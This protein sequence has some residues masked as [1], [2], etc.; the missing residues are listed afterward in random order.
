[1]SGQTEYFG[2][3]CKDSST[4]RSPGRRGMRRTLLA[5]ACAAGLAVCAPLGSEPLVF[6]STQLRPLQEATTMRQDILAGFGRPVSFEPLDDR[7]GFASRAREL[8]RQPGCRAVFGGLETDFVTLYRAGLLEDVRGILPTLGNRSFLQRFT[9]RG[10]FDSRGAYFVPWMQATYLMAANRRSLR[11]LPKGAD[12][13]H[14]TYRQLLD[15]AAEM[16][17]QAG[18]GMLGFPVGPKGLMPRF[19]E[20]YLYPSFT[21][22]VSSRFDAPEAQGMWQYLRSLYRYVAPS[23]LMLSRMDEA[24]L[25]GEVWVAWDHTARLVEAFRRRPDEFVA[26]PAPAGPMGRGSMTVLAGLGLPRGCS[27][28]EAGSLVEYLTRPEVQA[29]TMTRLGFLPV[30][31][32]SGRDDLSAGSRA[33]V[34][35]A[36]A[37]LN[38]AD[39]IPC[40]VP[41]LAGDAARQFDLVYLNAFSQIVLRNGEPALVLAAQQE[42]LAGLKAADAAAESSTSAAESEARGF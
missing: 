34:Q 8:A 12:I 33:L 40:S 30:V 22:S 1:M 18:R 13:N 4:G 19:L 7:P 36:V 21:G 20:G 5:A 11:Y 14:L 35:A 26:F 10:A 17:R 2:L 24:L 38:S 3:P 15:W 6:L 23:S 42:V 37:Q 9:G 28:E 27:D 41:A 32:V 25:N 29:Q 16:Y 31:D 39:G